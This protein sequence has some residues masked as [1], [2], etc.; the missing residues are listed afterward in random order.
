MMKTLQFILLFV[1]FVFKI[2]ASEPP[3]RPPI[4][5]LDRDQHFVTVD[6]RVNYILRPSIQ[7]DITSSKVTLMFD[8]PP[9]ETS[10][11]G[12]NVKYLL[13]LKLWEKIVS[14]KIVSPG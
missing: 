14:K 3:L 7:L 4:E 1:C 5:W 11:D 2:W 6:I 8:S 9:N 10:T 12:R 13:E